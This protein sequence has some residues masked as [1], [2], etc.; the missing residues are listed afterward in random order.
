MRL[1][2]DKVREVRPEKCSEAQA[3]GLAASR[4]SAGWPHQG[5]YRCEVAVG[6]SRCWHSGAV[7]SKVS[8]QAKRTPR[9]A[10]IQ[11]ASSR[12]PSHFS[13]HSPAGAI[14][15]RIRD[16]LRETSCSDSS[17]NNGLDGTSELLDDR[18]T[19]DVGR[20]F[21]GLRP[22]RSSMTSPA[23]RQSQLL[24]EPKPGSFAGSREIAWRLP[25]IT[26]SSVAHYALRLPVLAARRCNNDRLMERSV[27]LCAA[28]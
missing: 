14:R 25:G 6:T 2:S 26:A 21:D 7:D 20:I 4:A 1:N 23:D 10:L 19:A 13:S 12:M 11:Y 8:K 22:D 28:T 5:S 18:Q 9:V 16:S 3:P 15:S 17:D 27:P 24:P